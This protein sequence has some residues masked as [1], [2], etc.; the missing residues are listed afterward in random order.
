MTKIACVLQSA[1]NP[2]C[3]DVGSLRGMRVFGPNMFIMYG[4]AVFLSRVIGM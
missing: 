1:T 4:M 2:L 3:G